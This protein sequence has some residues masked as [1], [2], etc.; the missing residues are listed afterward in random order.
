[1]LDRVERRPWG[2]NEGDMTQG[3]W[4]ASCAVFVVLIDVSVGSE[5]LCEL[6]ETKGQ[7][8]P[9]KLVTRRRTEEWL[10]HATRC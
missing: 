6:Y 5:D 10:I 3:E 1:V 4:K 8:M 9:M 7:L 2:R